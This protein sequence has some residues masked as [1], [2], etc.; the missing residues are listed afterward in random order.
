MVE[1]YGF[2]FDSSRCV[3]CRTCE[4]ACKSANDVEPGVRW[5]RLTDEWCGEFPRVTRTF[6]SVA[7]MHCGFPACAAACPTGAIAKRPDDGIVVVDRARC[8][9]CGECLPACPY[10]VPEFGK[11]GTMQKCDFCIGIG[12]EPACT[13]SCPTEALRFGSLKAL[14]R[15][16]EGKTTKPMSGGTEPSIVVVI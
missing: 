11:D 9:G 13:Q 7:C 3:Q 1:Q 14:R 15:M 2:Y 4:L 12:G 10:D 5:R 6:F 16:A 8:D